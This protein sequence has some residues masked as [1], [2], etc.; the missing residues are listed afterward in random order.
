MMSA[1][2]GGVPAMS[3]RVCG[4]DAPAAAFC[5]SCGAQLSGGGG[6][7]RDYLRMGA[8]AA[9]PGEQVLRLSVSSSLFPHLPHQSRTAFRVGLAVLFLVLV[10]LALLR[11]QAPMIVISALALPFMFVLYLYAVDIHRDLTIRSL[12]PTAIL[13]IA[14]GAGWALLTGG[15]VADFYD[16][17]LEAAGSDRQA[18]LVGVGI[19]I[20][21]AVVMLVPAV[22]MRFLRP[23]RESLD[24]FV[25]GALGAI[26]FTAAAT[27]TRLA[28]QF[29][30]GV[31]AGDR[32]PSV[33]LVQAGLQG[34][35]VPLTSAAL[36]GL[37]GAAMWFGRPKLLVSSVLVTLVVYG[38]L[39]LMEV[40]PVLQGLHFGAHTMI[41]IFALLALR[42]GLQIALLHE[43]HDPVD[44]SGL[45]LCPHCDHVVPD[46]AFCPNCGVAA[47][48]ASRTSRAARRAVVSAED[49]ET[50]PGYAVLAGSYEVA[51][52]RHTTNS[53]LLTTLGAG[54]VVAVAAGVTAAVLATPAKPRYTC[55]PDCGRPPIGQPIESNPRFFSADGEFSVQYPGPG[56]AYEPTLAP[57]G[58]ELNFLVGD[59]GTMQLF[60]L[61]ADK[62]TPKQILDGLIS[63]HYPNAT[64][65][66]EIPNAMVGYEPGY[67]VV[68]DEY[69]QDS[70]GEFTRLRL[71]A[72][73]AVKND[74]AL[75]AA[76][77]G[78][79]HEFSP[80]F[81]TGH[82]SGVNLQLAMD[83]GKYVNSFRWRSGASD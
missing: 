3:C 42:F 32:P 54:I 14:L 73:I 16:V 28:P 40:A 59:T 71:V 74:Y 65:E 45:V 12:V 78:P 23:T 55:P 48:A 24:G 13:G 17:S 4:T 81:G 8:Y 2:T 30:T 69:P 18:L 83:M 44:P 79:Y 53:W 77:I 51:P 19:P 58:V 49:A 34:V 56:S 38:V 9:A 29:A 63:E 25:I 35:A 15:V 68:V 70:S 41:A 5:G 22:V 64:V 50:R 57:D 33:L 46:M 82:P 47:R 7:R 52:V 60:G 20:G 43:E 72:L 39:G 75:V 67:G 31:I 10:A 66:Y 80:D 61:P 27:L 6:E 76:A 37:V 62:R 26:C 1:G 11:W 21:S 36:G